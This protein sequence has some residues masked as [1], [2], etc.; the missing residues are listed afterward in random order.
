MIAI[1]FTEEDIEATLI[2]PQAILRHRKWVFFEG[3]ID[4]WKLEDAWWTEEPQSL[5]YF[6]LF[7]SG[8]EKA[9]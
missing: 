4:L 5:T 2:S 9:I 6:K 1:D 8:R 7:V 3:I